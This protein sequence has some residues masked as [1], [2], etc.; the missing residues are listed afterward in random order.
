MDPT[1]CP[2]KVL[3]L[4]RDCSQEDIKRAYRELAKV[5][6]GRARVRGRVR[7]RGGVP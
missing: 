4:A 5:R 7:A 1:T 6:G 3:G 2:Y